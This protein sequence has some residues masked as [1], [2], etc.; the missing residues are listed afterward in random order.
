MDNKTPS[1]PPSPSL[2]SPAS[3]PLP[4][5]QINW[6]IMREVATY[7]NEYNIQDGGKE[8]ILLLKLVEHYYNLCFVK[9]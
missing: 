2:P 7:D 1:P 4:P 9:N 5:S 6:T 8:L 3:P